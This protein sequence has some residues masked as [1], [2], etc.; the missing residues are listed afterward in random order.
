MEYLAEESIEAVVLYGIGVLVR[1][2]PPLRDAVHKLLIAQ[3][4]LLISAK[5]T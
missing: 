2:P 5:E 4:E 3:E 1:V